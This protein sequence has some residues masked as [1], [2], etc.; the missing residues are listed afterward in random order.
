MKWNHGRTAPTTVNGTSRHHLTSPSDEPQV[1]STISGTARHRLRSPSTEPHVTG[2]INGTARH[3]LTS[4]STEPH[5][6]G[7][8]DGT[9]RHHLPSPSTAR[10]ATSK[11][12]RHL[13]I[14][15]Q[16]ARRN[17]SASFLFLQRANRFFPRTLD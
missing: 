13:V 17:R 2:T 10:R 1:K 12:R 15:V 3:H 5:V 4:P 8:I 7:T 14:F 11:R 9:A 6:T 16:R